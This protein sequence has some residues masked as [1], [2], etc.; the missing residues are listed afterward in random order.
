MCTTRR[1][2]P[3]N[4][5]R[6]RRHSFWPRG[7]ATSPRARSPLRMV[8]RVVFLFFL[9]VCASGYVSPP[10][11]L[12][13]GLVFG[14]AFPHPYSSAAKKFSRFLLQASGVGLGVGMNPHEVG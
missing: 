7:A 5:S 8:S 9:L 14:L 1:P 12:A 11:A 13:M 6:G 4:L 3:W 10:V 2:R